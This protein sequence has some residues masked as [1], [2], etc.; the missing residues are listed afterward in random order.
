[1]SRAARACADTSPRQP[2]PS[3]IAVVASREPASAT[4]TS[5]TM[6]AAAPET[7]AA[8]V[9][10]SV[11]SLSCVAITTLSMT[12]CPSSAPNTALIYRLAPR[13][14]KEPPLSRPPAQP[15]TTRPSHAAARSLCSCFVPPRKLAPPHAPLVPTRQPPAGAY[16]LLAQPPCAGGR[17]CPAA[18]AVAGQREAASRRRRPQ[19]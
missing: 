17:L 7:N 2:A 10:S 14:E 9:G 1:W 16:V 6:P 18:C 8:S 11:R 5:R 12:L 15:Q 4:I 3:A 13:A 19:C